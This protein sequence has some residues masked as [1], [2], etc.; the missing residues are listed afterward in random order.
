MSEIYQL[1]Y[2]LHFTFISSVLP[3]FVLQLL[4]IYFSA[5]LLVSPRYLHSSAPLYV[6][7]RRLCIGAR[8][9]STLRYATSSRASF[10]LVTLSRVSTSRFLTSPYFLLPITTDCSFTQRQTAAST[11]TDVGKHFD[12]T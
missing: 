12:S 11:D 4:H 6:A 9:S 8:L 2:S 7:L 1:A 10:R 5:A 3:S